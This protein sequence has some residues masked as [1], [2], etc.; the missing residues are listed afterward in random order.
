MRER[1]PGD[2]WA[3]KLHAEMM[4]CLH[5]PRAALELFFEIVAAELDG[6]GRARAGMV[7]IT[8]PECLLVMSLSEV[9][10]TAATTNADDDDDAAPVAQAGVWLTRRSSLAGGTC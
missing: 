9:V 8:G 10:R 6:G 3:T 5:A 1:F 4:L 7:A 2:A